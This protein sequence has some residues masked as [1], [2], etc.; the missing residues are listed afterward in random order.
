MPRRGAPSPP[1]FDPCRD[2]LWISPGIAAQLGGL[3]FQR[4]VE[5][6]LARALQDASDLGE[7]ISTASGELAQL[8]H[9]GRVFGLGQVA[10]LGVVLRLAGQLGDE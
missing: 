5:L 7:Q 3:P 1:F 6:P 10:P 4:L 2:F 8:L 9:R